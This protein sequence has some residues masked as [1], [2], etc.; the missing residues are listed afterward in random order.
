MTRIFYWL[1]V[2]LLAALVSHLAYTLFMP[3]YEARALVSQLARDLRANSFHPLQGAALRRLVRHPLPDAAYG[4]CLLDL[5]PDRTVALQGPA[6]RTLWALTLH[7]ERGDVI[8]AITDRHVPE[9]RLNVRFQYRPPRTAGEV[10]LP[11][12]RKAELVVPLAHR[13]AV[14]VLEAFPW[15]PGQRQL[16]RELL[17]KLRCEARREKMTEADAAT[18]AGKR[19]LPMPRSR[20]PHS[21]TP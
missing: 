5:A 20:P 11:K 6:L 13:R 10:I 17:G 21:S 16:L 15:H 9:G 7:S 19:V 8:Y 3:G 2:F 14:L 18:N 1:G 4:A 12:L